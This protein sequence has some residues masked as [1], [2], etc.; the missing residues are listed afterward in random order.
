MIEEHTLTATKRYIKSHMQESMRGKIER[1]LVELIT[2]SD[3]SYR[4]I[5]DANR[6]QIKSKISVEIER[7]HTRRSTII[8]KDRSYGND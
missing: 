7:H 1:G 4:D 8:V 5:E 6:C 2:N 3:D